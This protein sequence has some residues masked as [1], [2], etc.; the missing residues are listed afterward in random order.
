M[1]LYN[2]I[3]SFAALTC[4]LALLTACDPIEP[5]SDFNN[6]GT[7]ITPQELKAA[8]EVK[9]MPNADDK[10]E[11]D[12]CIIVKN[13]RPDVGGKWH[14][15]Y[16]GQETTYATDD[17][18]IT[19]QANGE[20]QLYYMGISANTVVKTEPFTLTVTNVF[21]EWSGFLTSAEN[22][23]DK[24]AKRKWRFRECKSGSNLSICNNGA[25]GA[26]NYYAPEWYNSWWGNHTGEEAADYEMV[27]YF[28]DSK[29]T[30]SD[31]SGAV[32]YTGMFSFTHDEPDYW[33]PD[34]N[35][36]AGGCGVLGQLTV[37][38]PLIGS[39]WDDCRAQKAG[40]PNVF[41]ILTLTDKYLTIYHPDVYSGAKAWENCGWYAYFEA[42][43]E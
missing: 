27:F 2:I 19:C 33:D 20:Y 4:G 6:A 17:G 42:V 3:P 34:A 21:D 16:N 38:V 26:W 5:K 24:Q 11:G 13:N 40:E 8:L 23:A 30:T 35:G 7:P 29:I 32:K 18:I 41:W 22:K 25:C 28:G 37:D 9:Q 43:E 39:Q 36:G 12:Q 14:L 31:A 15:V 1:K 10:V